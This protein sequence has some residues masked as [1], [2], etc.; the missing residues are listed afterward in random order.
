MT[1]FTQKES[2]YLHLEDLI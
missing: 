1:K 2:I